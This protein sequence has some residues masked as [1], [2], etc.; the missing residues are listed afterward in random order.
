MNF[1][2]ALRNLVA[3]GKIGDYIF[4]VGYDGKVILAEKNSQYY[5]IKKEGIVE[6]LNDFEWKINIERLSFEEAMKQLLIKGKCVRNINW[7]KDT[8]LYRVKSGINIAKDGNKLGC[9][10]EMPDFTEED[11]VDNWS[12]Y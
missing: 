3:T 12:L 4:P 6:N 1:Y 10:Y 5:K 7:E 2:E 11:F 8:F 9:F